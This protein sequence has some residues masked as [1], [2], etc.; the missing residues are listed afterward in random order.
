[1]TEGDRPSAR[2][3]HDLSRLTRSELLRPA[4]LAKPRRGS[5]EGSHSWFRE[6][7]VGSYFGGKVH[8]AASFVLG[9]RYDPPTRVP[10]V[11][12]GVEKLTPF[13][14]LLLLLSLTG[15]VCPQKGCAYLEPQ[16]YLLKDRSS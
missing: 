12:G 5:G 7:F 10:R 15:F 4:P 16:S 13:A 6:P 8:H 1:M 3:P 2:H 11:R 9:L 14:Q